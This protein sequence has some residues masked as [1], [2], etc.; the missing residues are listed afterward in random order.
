[1]DELQILRDEV[2]VG[3]AA[4]GVLQ[5]PEIVLALFLRDGAAHVGDVMG[6][7]GGIARPDQ[8]VADDRL[9][10]RPKRG[11]GRDHPRPRQRH[12]LPGPGLVLLILRKGIDVR[13]QRPGTARRA[14]P[15]VD[16]VQHA[17]IGARGEGADQALGEAREVMR[18][19]QRALAVGVGILGIEIVEQDQVEIGRRGHLA[20]AEPAHRDDGGLL[21]LDAAVL[22][23]EA[24][25]HQAVHGVDDALGDVGKGGAGLTRRDRAGQDARADQ[26]QALLAEQAQ[27]VEKLLIGIG[28]LQC[29]REPRGQFAPIGHRAEEA[30]IDQAVHQLRLPRQHV[31]EPGR[32]A[33][34]Q[35]HQRDQLAVLP[36]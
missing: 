7:G 24:V 31:A 33:E 5:I 12:V 14:Q 21:P 17:V 32:R 3:D 1:M 30:R 28:V 34:H 10:P 29:R 6:G 35:R 16:V 9:D 25:G 18:A 20:A 8:G 15:H 23:G 13:R 11:R 22:R 26:E 4:G 27:P 36:Q 2:D 19:L